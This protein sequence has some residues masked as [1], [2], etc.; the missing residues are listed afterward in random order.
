MQ[1]TLPNQTQ[2]GSQH[3]QGPHTHVTLPFSLSNQEDN[4]L[5]AYATTWKISFFHTII[6]FFKEPLINQDKF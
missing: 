1:T 2:P 5:K 3:N 6:Q 4:G